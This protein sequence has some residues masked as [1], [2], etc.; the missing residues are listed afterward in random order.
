MDT[1][2]PLEEAHVLAWLQQHP[3]FFAKHP[4][5]LS[6]ATPDPGKVLSLEAG[7]LQHL[8]RQ[9]D[10]L[11]EKLDAILDRL[12]RNEEIYRAFH[13]I[14]TRMIMAT[15]PWS[16]IALATQEPEHLFHIQRVTVSLSTQEPALVGLFRNPPPESLEERLFILEHPL[17]VQTLGEG[18]APIIRVGREGKHRPLYFGQQAHTVRSEVLVPLYA[19]EDE[20][21]PRRRLIGS[22]NLGGETPNRFLP[23][24]ATDLL[25]DLANV[26]SLCLVRMVH[27]GGTGIA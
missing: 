22:L 15:A 21:N 14:Q 11:R 27:I 13:A 4:E 17:L 6:A 1:I 16:I 2:P 24:D 18:C 23:S 26:F 10:Q 20:A 8:R 19:P 9:N 12:V 25:Q 3:D 5:R 7:Q